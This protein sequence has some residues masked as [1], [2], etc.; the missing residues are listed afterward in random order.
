[1]QQQNQYRTLKTPTDGAPVASMTT[2]DSIDTKRLRK[3]GDGIS[4]LDRAS[5]MSVKNP[6]TVHVFQPS[7]ILAVVNKALDNHIYDNVTDNKLYTTS[8]DTVVYKYDE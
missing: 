2:P 1:M 7:N 4:V 5:T 8:Q 6:L 3:Y